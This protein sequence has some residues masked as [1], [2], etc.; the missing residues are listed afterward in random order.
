MGSVSKNSWVGIMVG[1]L[2]GALDGLVVGET[3]GEADGLVVGVSEGEADGLVVGIS[4]GVA[5]GLIE[6][7][8]DGHKSPPRVAQSYCPVLQKSTAQVQTREPV[9]PPAV[10]VME[11]QA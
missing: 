2:D 10:P 9:L 8:S 7:A 3:E 6:G 5:E 4:D 11:V 1:V